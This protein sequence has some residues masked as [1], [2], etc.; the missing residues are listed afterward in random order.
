[1]GTAGMTFGR[2][3]FLRSGHEQD[4]ALIAHELVHVAQW[5]EL[6]PV[7]FLWRYLTPYFLF[8]LNGL[9][10][11]EAYRRIPLE[12]EA[13]R[14]ARRLLIPPH[15]TTSGPGLAGRPAGE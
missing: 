9:T 11:W 3:I 10:H 8:R 4:S 6:G 1:M 2:N 7:L 5:R 12:V 15:P 13:T 14:A